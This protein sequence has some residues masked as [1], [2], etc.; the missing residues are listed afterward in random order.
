MIHK[1]LTV[2]ILAGGRSSRMGVDKAWL[3]FDG[4]PLVEHLARRV[5]PLA[6][7]I[8]FSTN[9]PE[10][11]LTLLGALPVPAHT[12]ADRY[13]GAGPLAGLQAGLLA[14]QNELVLA[15]ATDMPSV[16]LA[17]LGYL[18][19]Q[20]SD[21]DVV[22]P[23]LPGDESGRLEAEPL[24]AV[25]RR[26]CLPALAAHLAAGHRRLISFLPDVKVRSVSPEECARFDPQ[27][28]SF[29]NVNTPEEWQ[30]AQRY[31]GGEA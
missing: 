1:P 17:L 27:F 23:W 30:A 7:E 22:M 6:G 4:I 20:A 24:H 13:P 2:L 14:A 29:C 10:A 15:L 21:Y 8:V 12:V 25:Y 19:A 26:S 3:A 28:R 11:Y 31:M 5:A 18:V 16:N 9:T